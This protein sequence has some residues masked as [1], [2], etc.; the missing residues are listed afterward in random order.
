V[1]ELNA[2]AAAVAD[3]P[4]AVDQTHRL[5]LVDGVGRR[6]HTDGFHRSD[7]R[8]AH[9]SLAVQDH[10]DRQ[11]GLR[12]VRLLRLTE[13]EQV[14]AR[15]AGAEI[16]DRKSTRL[17]SSHVSISYA[18]FCLLPPSYSHALSLHDAL[19]I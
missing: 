13:V 18:V 4:N 16:P 12:D 1:G 14:K 17:N 6:R 7:L 19:P 11:L 9:G 10:H 8:N 2:H 15:E 5:E 3:V